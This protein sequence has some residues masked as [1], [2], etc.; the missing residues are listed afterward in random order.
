MLSWNLRQG[1]M[2]HFSHSIAATYGKT[3]LTSTKHNLHEWQLVNLYVKIT[4][5]CCSN[6]LKSYSLLMTWIHFGRSAICHNTVYFWISSSEGRSKRGQTY[7]C[8]LQ[9]P[10]P[11]WT[12]LTNIFSNNQQHEWWRHI[13]VWFFWTKDNRRSGE[14]TISIEMF[15]YQE[16][17]WCWHH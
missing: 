13:V 2:F 15:F 11:S 14:L 9:L 16:I 4:H 6:D 8:L 7:L 1:A 10:R 5:F 17:A 12:P 3:A